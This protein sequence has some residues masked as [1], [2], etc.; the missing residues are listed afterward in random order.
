MDLAPTLRALFLLD[1]V[2]QCAKVDSADPNLAPTEIPINVAN[3]AV[4]IVPTLLAV[5]AD[6]ALKMA[7]VVA[8]GNHDRLVP[9]AVHARPVLVADSVGLDPL[10]LVADS[11]GLVPPELVVDLVGPAPAVHPQDCL[12]V[13]PRMQL[14]LARMECAAAKKKKNTNYAAAACR[15][16]MKTAK[17]EPKAPA[18]AKATSS[19]MK[20]FTMV[21][22]MNPDHLKAL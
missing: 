19:S 1:N 8:D 13:R 7:T 9:V 20:N 12:L 3:R 22:R 21:R 10:E 6:H 4:T 2:L 16:K 11:A 14:R 18:E 15:K 17:R 5:T